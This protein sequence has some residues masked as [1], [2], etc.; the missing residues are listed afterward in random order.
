[1][2]LLRRLRAGI[3][4]LAIISI[5]ALLFASPV[6]AQAV[7]NGAEANDTVQIVKSSLMGIAIGLLVLTIFYWIHTDPKRRARAHVRKSERIEA[8]AA[9]KSDAAADLGDEPGSSGA[10]EQQPD[11]DTVEEQEEP[12]EE[13]VIVDDFAASEPDELAVDAI[14]VPDVERE[15]S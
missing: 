2:S 5:C 4:C 7:T 13:L 6:G 3:G 11:E 1:M 9:R 12:D 10:F 14:G 15:V 8:R